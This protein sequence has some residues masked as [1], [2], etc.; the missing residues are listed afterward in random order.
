VKTFKYVA[1]ERVSGAQEHGVLEAN[2]AE[3]GISR[4]RGNDLVVVS[5]EEVRPERSI[6]LGKNR[7]LGDKTLALVSN[8]FAIVLKSGLSMVRAIGF[9]AEQVENQ[10]L[11]EVLKDVQEDVAAGFGLADSLDKYGQGLPRTFVESVRAGEESGNLVEVFER[12]SSYYDRTAKVRSK[13]TSALIY[14]V[15]VLCVAVVVVTI[16]M[17]FAVPT[18]KSTFVQMGLE[19]PWPTRAMIATSDFL[20]ANILT[21]VLVVAVVVVFMRMLISANMQVR[22]WW[23]RLGTR[24]PVLGR[25]NVATSAAQLCSTMAT[26]VASGIPVVRAIDVTA[27]S[28]SNAYMS[29]ALQSTERAVESG[30]TLSWAMTSTNAF[31][32]FVTEMCAMGEQTGSLDETLDVAA[33]YFENEVE[34]RTDRAVRLLEPIMIVVLAV[35]VL[36]IL[37]AVYLPMFGIYSNF[38]TMV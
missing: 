22:L 1:R 2:T 11:Q 5:F 12:L 30:R 37:L 23:S 9:V 18:F 24:L 33:G 27:R 16:I 3:E 17:I 21:I 8:Q 15:F 34:T 29:N 31:P 36:V 35:I 26:L 10:R 6:T 7:P 20:S 28:M 32:H 4:L 19:L 25:I 14:P 38:T 13:A